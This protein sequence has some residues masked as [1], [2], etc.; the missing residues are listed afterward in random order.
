[1]RFLSLLSL[2]LLFS[3]QFAF[4]LSAP[5]KSTTSAP[6]QTISLPEIVRQTLSAHFGESAIHYQSIDEFADSFNVP[7]TMKKS[8]GLFV[9][10]S[11]HGKTRACWGTVSPHCSDLVRSTIYTTEEAL[12]KEYR[13]PKIKANEWK[14]LKPQV[15][16]VQSLKAISSFHDLNPLTDGLMVS[17]GG[18]AAV[19]LPGEAIDAHHE[20]VICKLKAGI[21]A[22]TPCQ[23]YRIKADVYK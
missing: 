13:Y 5:T 14:L 22:S 6:A 10:L 21:P 12:T 3:S 7:A 18:R 23:L 16:V 11:I 20:M 4:A 17:K 8:A 1:M 15:T 2:F 9:T 19:V